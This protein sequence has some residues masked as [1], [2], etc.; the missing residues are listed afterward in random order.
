MIKAKYIHRENMDV[1]SSGDQRKRV[2]A[3]FVTYECPKDEFNN[4]PHEWCCRFE[5]ARG[6]HFQ[7]QDFPNKT[8]ARATQG[9]TI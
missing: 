2:D 7:M 6:E 9:Y 5:V 8:A 3:Y 4:T 1:R